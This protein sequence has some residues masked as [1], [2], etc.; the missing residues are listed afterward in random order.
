MGPPSQSK[1]LTFPSTAQGAKA[2]NRT[3]ILLKLIVNIV[4]MTAGRLESK[5]A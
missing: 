5:M 3:Y 1:A 2:L 4:Q